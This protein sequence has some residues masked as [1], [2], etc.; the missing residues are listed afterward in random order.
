MGIVDISE[1][2]GE[3]IK[4]LQQLSEKLEDLTPI[5]REISEKMLFAV[6]QNFETE[7]AR[8]GSKWEKLRPSTIAQRSKSE[9]R[10]RDKSGSYKKYKR[11]S[12]KTGKQKGD[13]VTRKVKPTWPGKILQVDSLLLGS[14]ISYYG[15]DYA[16]V[17]TNKIYGP[18]HQFG[19]WAG[20]GKK[21]WIDARP[22]FELTDQDLNDIL[23]FVRDTLGTS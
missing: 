13:Y 10:V 9:V 22:F 19:G 3:I 14:V 4:T 5:N 2:T 21:V 20:K 8:L 16:G 12:K 6:Q 23:D 15:K 11:G 7:G 18:I 17:G 1:N